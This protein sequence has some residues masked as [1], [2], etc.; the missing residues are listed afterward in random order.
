MSMKA[1]GAP[2]DGVALTI[3]QNIL[4]QSLLIS[5][6]ELCTTLRIGRTKA[7]EIIRLQLVQSKTIG[8]RRLIVRES[9]R[10]YALS[11]AAEQVAL[12]TSRGATDP[13]AGQAAKCMGLEGKQP[14]SS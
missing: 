5:V 1:E 12:T 13:P 6:D 4:E 10:S 7:Y 8:R 14:S 2:Q 3:F 11:S 9:V